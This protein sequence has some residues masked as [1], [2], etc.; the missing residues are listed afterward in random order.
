ML[1]F[2]AALLL[3]LLDNREG[4]LETESAAAVAAAA[5]AAELALLTDGKAISA[6]NK[7]LGAGKLCVG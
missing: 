5:A 7:S 3:G 4:L 1:N 2:L 6:G